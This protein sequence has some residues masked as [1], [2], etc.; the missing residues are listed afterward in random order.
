M[1]WMFEFRKLPKC[2]FRNIPV[3]NIFYVVPYLVICHRSFNNVI[4]V[5]Y[6]TSAI[7][8][9]VKPFVSHA[10]KYADCTMVISV[11]FINID[12]MMPF[13]A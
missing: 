8:D 4:I 9:K 7:D 12:H 3:Y 5:S 1:G 13:L 11:K 6:S 10:F 2:L